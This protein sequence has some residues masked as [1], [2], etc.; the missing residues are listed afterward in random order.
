MMTTRYSSSSIVCALGFA[1]VMTPAFF[2]HAQTA[3]DTSTNA[4]A[5]PAAPAVTAPADTNAPSATA[6]T[7]RPTTYALEKGDTLDSVAK[8]FGTSIKALAKLNNI[9]KSKY[10]KLQLG[11]VLKIPPATTTD[12]TT[13]AAK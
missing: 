10:K 13:P 12:T 9:D 5:A 2:A 6:P 7:E 11:Q 1:L 8:K 4:P 3:V